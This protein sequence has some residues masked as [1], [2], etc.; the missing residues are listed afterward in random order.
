ML[1]PPRLCRV[2][3]ATL[4]RGGRAD[5]VPASALH[6][7]A[8][9]DPERGG[10]R[11]VPGPAFTAETSGPRVMSAAPAEETATA[12]VQDQSDFKDSRREF[13]EPKRLMFSASAAR[14]GEP[15]LFLPFSF[16]LCFSIYSRWTFFRISF[17]SEHA[18]IVFVRLN[19]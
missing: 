14:L 7:R 3:E 18:F 19:R 4:L 1:L 15:R 10:E 13:K 11:R 9:A 17:L 2:W 12:F 8:L 6:S 5:G 16:R